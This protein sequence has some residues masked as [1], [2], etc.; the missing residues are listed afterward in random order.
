MT[1]RMLLG[2]SSRA[3]VNIVSSSL[4]L[5]TPLI[6]LFQEVSRLLALLMYRY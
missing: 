4:A 2:G 3:Y 1:L 6:Y 5:L